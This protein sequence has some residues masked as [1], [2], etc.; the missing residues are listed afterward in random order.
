MPNFVPLV[1]FFTALKRSG[2]TNGHRICS[3]SGHLKATSNIVSHCEA[4]GTPQ[5][6]GVI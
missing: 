4:L 2:P 1:S 3:Q 6:I 5:M